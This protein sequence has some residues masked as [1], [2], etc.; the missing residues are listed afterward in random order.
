MKFLG[1]ATTS[2]SFLKSHRARETKGFVP[3]EWYDSPYK[4]D[5]TD[6]PPYE[7]F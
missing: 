1:G 3:Y 5:C 4:L 2:D 7:R 6:L